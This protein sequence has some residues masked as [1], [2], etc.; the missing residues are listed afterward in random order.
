[1]SRSN[2]ESPLLKVFQSGLAQ[3]EKLRL[4]AR[5]R[6]VIRR[7]IACAKGELG[8]HLYQCQQCG[9]THSVPHS[10]RDRHCPYCQYRQS[11]KWLEAQEKCLLPVPYFH[12][13][14]TL[15]HLLNGLIRQNP[16]TALGLLFSSASSTLL[17]FF[18]NNAGAR[19]GLT[20]VLH[21]WGQTLCE[22]YHLH[23]LVTGGGLSLSDD[24]WI[25]LSPGKQAE[26][27]LF[28]TA[29]LAPVFRARYLAGLEQAF[30]KGKLD[31]HQQ[32][33]HWGEEA[34]FARQLRC[35]A[36]RKWNVYCKAPFA[37]P[38]QV[39]NYL[40]LYTHRVAISPKRIEEIDPEKGTVR[41][42]YKDYRKAAKAGNSKMTLETSEFTRRFAQHILPRGFCKIRHYGILSTRNRKAKVAQC[43]YFLAGAPAPASPASPDKATDDRP[44]EE[45]RSET[46]TASAMT[47]AS[48][49]CPGCGS[50]KLVLIRII[51]P[52][53]ATNAMRKIGSALPLGR[54][55]PAP[56]P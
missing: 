36:K 4:N 28:A 8:A 50:A 17:G 1:M 22:H 41:F 45:Q 5:Q 35:L 21:S 11:R 54:P 47:T 44:A 53:F 42:C 38:R 7:I 33:S 55:P 31:F 10:C 39:L 15:P 19:P 25:E 49:C 2:G 34:T 46:P 27:W 52:G 16:K 29:A 37:G 3:P 23:V 13:V 32:I 9:E 24:E 18:E 6:E 26:R 56:P 40:S 20:A 30:G 48:P 43:R 51:S 12:V 14:F